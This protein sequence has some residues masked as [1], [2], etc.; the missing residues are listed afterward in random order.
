MNSKTAPDSSDV[1][2]GRRIAA[3]VLSHLLGLSADYTLRRY[4]P[5]EIDP[6]WT[7]LGRVLL[8]HMQDHTLATGDGKPQ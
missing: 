4:V 5:A 6:S 1:E 8:R 3:A 7:D 2:L